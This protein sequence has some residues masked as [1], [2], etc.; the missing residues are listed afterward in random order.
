MYLSSTQ[1]I[2]PN[3]LVWLLHMLSVWDEA[4]HGDEDQRFGTRGDIEFHTGTGQ[5]GFCVSSFCPE[6]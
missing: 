2:T 1:E 6:R 3:V 5:A 4:V